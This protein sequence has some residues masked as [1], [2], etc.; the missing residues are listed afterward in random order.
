[1][2]I[3]VLIVDDIVKSIIEYDEY[4][5]TEDLYQDLLRDGVS[6]EK[7]SYDSYFIIIDTLFTFSDSEKKIKSYIKMYYD[8]LRTKKLKRVIDELL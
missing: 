4:F 3:S 8:E 1:M 6:F 2:I 5:M 7:E